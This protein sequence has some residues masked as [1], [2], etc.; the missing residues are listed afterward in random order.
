M[1][2]SAAM[3]AGH[4]A[5]SAQAAQSRSTGRLIHKADQQDP[6]HTAQDA[7]ATTKTAMKGM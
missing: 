6:P 4:M 1:S 3:H 7:R 2:M 5:H